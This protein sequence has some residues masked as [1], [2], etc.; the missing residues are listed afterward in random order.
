MK[1]LAVLFCLFLL[2]AAAFAQENAAS[3]KQ[4][5]ATIRQSTNWE[6]P[7]AAKKA[8]EQI[9]E[10]SKKLIMTG[11]TPAELPQGLTKPEAEEMQQKGVDDK[12]KLWGQMMN[13][14][15]EGGAWDL[16]KPL[17][18]EIAQEYKDDE[19]PTVKNR[20]YLDEMTLLYI[21]MSSPTVQLVIDQMDNY[22]SIQILVITGGK[23]GSTVNLENLI[24]KAAHYPLKQLYIINFKAFV[25]KVP[26][27]ISNFHDLKV[28]ALYNN[29]ISKLPT[30]FS[31]L[32]KLKKFYIDMNPIVALAPTISKLNNLDSLGIA[33]T[34]IDTDE[35]VRIKQL[36]PNCKILTQ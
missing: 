15:H 22:K 21:D 24:A 10:L 31:S 28:L 3:I 9:R 8:N 32:S 29:K 17:R 6:D 36:L 11:K 26:I 18:E 27:A 2:E 34:Q 35:K 20:E 25:T 23:N 30:E 16:S 5:M 1:L 19:D 12:M 14:A 13:I 7:V 33:K 4:Q